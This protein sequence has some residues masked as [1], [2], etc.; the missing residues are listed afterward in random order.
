MS[1]GPAHAVWPCLQGDIN[2]WVPALDHFD[3]FLEE[4]TTKRADVQLKLGEE[5][6]PSDP[7]FPIDSCLAVLNAT[8][9]LLENC[10]N[11]A[12]YNSSE[13]RTVWLA[14]PAAWWTT[15]AATPATRA[16]AC[17]GSPSISLAA[18]SAA[19]QQVQWAVAVASLQAA[20][21]LIIR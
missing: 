14:R 5:G 6:V 13:V 8:C 18:T 3:A 2:H 7:A 20:A 11:K 9:V 12:A 1:L 16:A 10:S 21:Q 15:A 4:C 19:P 17:I